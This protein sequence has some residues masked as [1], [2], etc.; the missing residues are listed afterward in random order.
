MYRASFDRRIP[1]FAEAIQPKLRFLVNVGKW[2]SHDITVKV[3][4]NVLVFAP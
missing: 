2:D 1:N 3:T 4:V